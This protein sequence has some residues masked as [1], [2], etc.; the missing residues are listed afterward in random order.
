MRIF[1][2]RISIFLIVIFI[3]VVLRVQN[4]RNNLSAFFIPIHDSVSSFTHTIVQGPR[5][6]A[7]LFKNAQ[8]FEKEKEAFQARIIELEGQLVIQD[9]IQKDYDALRDQVG[10]APMDSI[11]ARSIISSDGSPF[12][13][14]LVNKGMRDGVK[15]GMKAII[16]GY[17]FAGTVKEV[18]DASARIALIS[19]AGEETPLTLAKQNTLVVAKGEGG[20]SLR[21]DFPRDFDIAK[22]DRLI[23]FHNQPWLAGFI[24]DIEKNTSQP[25]IRA[26]AG[27]PFHPK[28]ITVVTLIP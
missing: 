14:I 10:S 24:E 2:K 12:D 18:F 6:I 4:I 22:G 25:I 26:R 21:I 17:V 23:F 11:I 13:S 1:L 9:Q 20:L 15:N 7:L 27:L 16:N 3:A 8:S 19:Y 5:I 28:N